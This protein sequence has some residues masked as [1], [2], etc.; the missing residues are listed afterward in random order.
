[1][2]T[3][4]EAHFGEAAAVMLEPWGYRIYTAKP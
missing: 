1:V 2:F 3:G 4:Q